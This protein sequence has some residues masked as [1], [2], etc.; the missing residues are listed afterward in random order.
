MDKNHRFDR[1]AYSLRTNIEC[2]GNLL[3]GVT[4]LF[5]TQMNSDGQYT[6]MNIAYA[7]YVKGDFDFTTRVKMDDR[8]SLVMH[9]G[10]GIAY[11]YGN[12]RILPF[13]KRYFAGGANGMRGW[14]VRTL[15]PGSY[16]NGNRSIDF[17]NQSG[18]LK[19]DL[20]V[21]YRSQLFKMIHSAVF[22]DAGNIWTI[23]NYE[24]Q[25]GGQ[26]RFTT[27]YKDIA[28]SYG[29][30]IRL[31]F[32]MFV[33]RLDA[34]MKAINPAYSGMD[35]FPI[36]NPNFGRDFALHFAIGYPF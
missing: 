30:G 11:P 36:I 27:F 33:F 14:A 1:V 13:E 29:L 25:P 3:Y 16:R 32:D 20:S 7:Q 26:F 4:S 15:G 24:E 35:K 10:L 19:L 28:L 12:S 2:S 31:E 5:N 18:D 22:I 23:R 6:V 17:I 21:E 9:F 34:A 8:N